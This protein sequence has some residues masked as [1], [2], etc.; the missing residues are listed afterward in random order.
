MSFTDDE[1]GVDSSNPIEIY[2]FLGTTGTFNYTSANVPVQY[3]ADT[4]EPVSIQRSEISLGDV[5]DAQDV[6]ITIPITTELVKQYGFD[7]PPPNLFV[8]VFRMHGVEGTPTPW[9]TAQVTSIVM[10]DGVAKLVA[11]SVFNA[12]LS[13]DFPTL[14]YQSQCNHI[15]YS[16]RCGV[17]RNDFKLDATITSITDRTHLIIEG[18]DANADGY[19]T[20]GEIVTSTERR[21]IVAHTG[22]NITL[23]YP[24]KNLS[25]GDSITLYAGCDLNINTCKNKFNNLANFFGFPYTPSLNPFLVGLR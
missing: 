5:T 22:N 16:S 25:V 4:F 15:L 11:P 23:N 12:A 6:N 14:Y 8:Q 10:Q 13:T 17:D 3:G 20:A 18:A 19:F 7:I 1:T 9:L 21:L 24:F 2:R